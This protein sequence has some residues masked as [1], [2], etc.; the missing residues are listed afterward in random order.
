MG[1]NVKKV[2]LGV[3]FVLAVVVAVVS[4]YVASRQHLKFDAPLPAVTAS[5][6]TAVV[7]RGRY[8]IRNLASCPICHGDP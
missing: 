5:A 2:F 1:V 3:V 4:I 8:V 7:E 6:D